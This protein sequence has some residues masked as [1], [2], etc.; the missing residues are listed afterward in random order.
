MSSFV[1]GFRNETNQTPKN[2]LLVS[3]CR[4][5]EMDFKVQGLWNTEKYCR[6]PWLTDK[7]N[8]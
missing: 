5:D 3:T 1:E 2:K 4:A 7:K 8:F 6:R